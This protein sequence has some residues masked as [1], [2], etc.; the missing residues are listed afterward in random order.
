[1]FVSGQSQVQRLAA[2]L[3]SPNNH[4]AFDLQDISCDLDA[5]DQG[6]VSDS[7][8]S[9]ATASPLSRA[10]SKVSGECKTIPAKGLVGVHICHSIKSTSS[11]G[12]S[13]LCTE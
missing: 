4:A 12:R 6:M 13:T 8:S 5:M 3:A 10:V 7:S 1:M 11:G 9:S 2:F